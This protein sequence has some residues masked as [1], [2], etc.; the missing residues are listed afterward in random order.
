MKKESILQEYIK[1]LKAYVPDNRTSKYRRQKLIER[2]DRQI[3]CYIQ[4]FNT[5]LSVI[6][7]SRR[8]I[9]SKDMEDPHFTINHLDLIDTRDYST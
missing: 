2:R 9:T 7:R 3:Y 1:I 6:D 5:S 8:Q 4:D